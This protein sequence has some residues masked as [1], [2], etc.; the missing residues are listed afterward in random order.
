MRWRAALTT[1]LVLTIAAPVL[2]AAPAAAHAGA[3]NDRPR[4][5]SVAPRVPGL[6]VRVLDRARFELRNATGDR[7]VVLGY[8]GEPYL[9]LEAEGIWRNRRS[10]ATYLNRSLDGGDVPREA[11]AGARPRWERLPGAIDLVRWH[12]HRLHRFRS[13][14]TPDSWQIALRVDGRPIAVS[15]V[16]ERDEPPAWWP[17]ALLGVA[18][19]AALLLATRRRRGALGAGCL[20]LALVGVALGIDG[21]VGPWALVALG[22]VAAASWSV[23]GSPALAGAAGAV[24]VGVGLSDLSDLGYAHLGVGA[25]DAVH[26]AA[27]VLSLGLGAALAAAAL[28]AVLGTGPGAGV[29]RR[30]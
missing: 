9:R 10:P 18:G 14:A 26:R 6:T 22:L 4:L 7:V 21:G 16:I 1:A 30:P 15:G 28:A 19:A 17:W 11:D 29:S 13:V 3:T 8:E 27:V 12:D 20:A 25:P 23:R 5:V 24:G 2:G